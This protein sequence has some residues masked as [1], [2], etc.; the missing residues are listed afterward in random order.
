MRDGVKLLPPCTCPR[1]I[2]KPTRMLLIRTP[3]SVGPYGADKYPDRTRRPGALY[4]QGG[5]IFVYQDVRGRWMSEGEYVNVR[6][7]N[8][9]KKEKGNRRE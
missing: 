1:T 2:P 9:A 5:Y 3:Y 8:P 4:A 7:Y 6:P